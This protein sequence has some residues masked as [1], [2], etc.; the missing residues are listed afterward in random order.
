MKTFLQESVRRETMARIDR[1]KDDSKPL[2]G[3]FTAAAMLDHIRRATEMA[4]G[5]MEM[6]VKNTPIR[7]FPIK[8][9]FIYVLPFPKSLPTAPEL[10]SDSPEPVEKSKM[11]LM[12]RINA[13]DPRDVDHPIFGRLTRKAWGVLVYRH[14]DHHLR[15]FGV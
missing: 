9:L 8:Q 1:I 4:S 6:K 10:L 7:F 2:W 3:K 11:A 15:Q 14:L 12:Q 5:E 13:F